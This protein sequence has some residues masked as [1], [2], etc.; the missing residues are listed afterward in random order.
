MRVKSL[1]VDNK[2][3]L[4]FLVIFLQ[5]FYLFSEFFILSVKL[6]GFNLR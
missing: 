4:P 2:T 6:F 5:V 3:V 1:A